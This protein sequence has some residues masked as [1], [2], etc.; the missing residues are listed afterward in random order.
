MMIRIRP[1]LDVSLRIPLTMPLTTRDAHPALWLAHPTCI[2]VHPGARTYS[3]H[4]PCG[5]R[6]SRNADLTP[7]LLRPLLNPCTPS[8]TYRLVVHPAI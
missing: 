4:H 6:G 5:N 2:C 3:Q 7:D 1:D 8:Q